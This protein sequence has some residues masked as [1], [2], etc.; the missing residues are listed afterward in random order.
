MTS[1]KPT[2]LSESG[3]SR[4][5]K[6]LGLSRASSKPEPSQRLSTDDFSIP[7]EI[8]QA[9]VDSP[10][11]MRL[12]NAFPIG[13]LHRGQMAVLAAWQAKFAPEVRKRHSK[14]RRRK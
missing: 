10:V 4:H 7:V 14:K 6:L 9:Y 1:F 2:R 13:T 12:S 3:N 8:A 11:G 5:A